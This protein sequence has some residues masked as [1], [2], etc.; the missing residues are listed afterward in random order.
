MGLYSIYYIP[1]KKM[2]KIEGVLKVKEVTTF[3]LENWEMEELSVEE[4]KQFSEVI[5][6]SCGI[7]CGGS[8]GTQ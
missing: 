5:F 7:G 2:K 4:V 1:L 8:S 3:E 6:A